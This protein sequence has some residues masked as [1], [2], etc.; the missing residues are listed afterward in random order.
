MARAKPDILAHQFT[1]AGFDVLRVVT[2]ECHRGYSRTVLRHCRGR[3]DDRRVHGGLCSPAENDEGCPD[4]RGRSRD[5]SV[6][7]AR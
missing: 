3:F 1:D 6:G 2:C 4:H 7:K 5:G